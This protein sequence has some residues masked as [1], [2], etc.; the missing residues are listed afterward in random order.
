ML[1][2]GSEGETKAPRGASACSEPL[3]QQQQ[4][5]RAV[6]CP[7]GRTR[8]GAMC[9]VRQAP[10][11]SCQAKGPDGIPVRWPCCHPCAPGEHRAALAPSS[12]RCCFVS[13][14]SVALGTSQHLPPGLVQSLAQPSCG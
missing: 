5:A 4:G 10:K 9:W 13:L 2:G 3:G 14:L 8:W 12:H 7:Q 11:V 6:L 1:T